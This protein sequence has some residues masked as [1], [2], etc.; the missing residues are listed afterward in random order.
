[1]NCILWT[2]SMISTSDLSVGGVSAGSTPGL[3]HVF[4]DRS[5]II[6]IDPDKEA[7]ETGLPFIQKTNMT[8]KIHF[9]QSIATKVEEGTF[10]FAF[11]LLKLV[12]VGG[13]MAYDKTL[14]SAS[15]SRIE[16]AHLSI[17]YELTLCKRLQ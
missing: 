5:I 13:I 16:L 8:H 7:Y 9:I 12:K 2:I 15:D 3:V 11:Q 1:M 17:G 4:Y 10:D 14:W 6:A